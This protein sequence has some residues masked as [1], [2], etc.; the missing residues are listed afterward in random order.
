MTRQIG[1]NPVME[2]HS[3][4]RDVDP[5]DLDGQ[6]ATN[7]QDDPNDHPVDDDF[8]PTD[9]TGPNAME[10]VH[11][12]SARVKELATRFMTSQTEGLTI[13]FINSLRYICYR[14]YLQ[15]ISILFSIN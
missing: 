1:P 5:T 14:Y 8:G 2:F 7:A 9:Q 12:I 4:M 6:T 13:T 10:I 3:D 11:P 15:F